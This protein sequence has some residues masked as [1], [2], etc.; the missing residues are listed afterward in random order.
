MK[1]II[2]GGYSTKNKEWTDETRDKLKAEGFDTKAYEWKHW[3]DIN[4]KFSEK[5]ETENLKKIVG[6]SEINLIAKSIGTLV[7]AMLI[8]DIKINK[9][10]FCGIPTNDMNE[11]EMR[12]YKILSDINPDKIIVF[13]NST[14]EHGNFEQV[15]N[16][17]S[18]IN[19]QI[20]I[21]EKPGSTHNY[22]YY[23]EFKEF[24]R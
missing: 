6:E 21:V 8:K 11:D 15:R 23:E 22:P 7:A 9:I 12:S 17:L 14:D 20:K 19:P 18:Q 13:Q 16:F 4:I 3:S 2:L 24:L 10:I 1:T 5:D